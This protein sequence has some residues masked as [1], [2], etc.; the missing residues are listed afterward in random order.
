MEPETKL[1]SA[2]NGLRHHTRKQIDQTSDSQEQ[3]QNPD[4]QPAA[5]QNVAA[6]LL[7]DHQ[8]G[9]RLEWLHGHRHSVTQRSQNLH[10]AKQNERARAVEMRRQDHADDERQVGTDIPESAGEFVSVETDP[11]SR[12]SRLSYVWI[13]RSVLE[14]HGA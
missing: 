4:R 5:E 3:H 9:H 1:D 7:R 11:A 10:R 14:G 13:C 2:N 12:S 8:G 6:D